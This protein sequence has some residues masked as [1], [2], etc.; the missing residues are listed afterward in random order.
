MVRPGDMLTLTSK[1][2]CAS[3]AI[4]FLKFNYSKKYPE[5]INKSLYS[6][7]IGVARY[8]SGRLKRVHLERLPGTSHVRPGVAG[9]RDLCPQE[10]RYGVIDNAKRELFLFGREL[11]AY[12]RVSRGSNSTAC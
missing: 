5:K 11:R 10:P 1:R 2:L 12:V 7:E 4:V 8:R 9:D 3:I 6:I